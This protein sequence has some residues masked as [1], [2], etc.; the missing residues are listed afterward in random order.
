VVPVEERTLSLTETPAS[1]SSLT[2]TATRFAEVAPKIETAPA[3]ASA[4][5]AEMPAVDGE[6][7]AP[8]MSKP[9]GPSRRERILELARQHAR[10]PLPDAVKAT[11]EERK[12]AKRLE[13]E[14]EKEEEE[15]VKVSMRDRLWKLMGGRNWL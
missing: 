9:K 2:E 8:G 14:R 1:A 5:E 11:A 7:P 12:E 3:D 4:S 13:R 15:R 10:T 6:I